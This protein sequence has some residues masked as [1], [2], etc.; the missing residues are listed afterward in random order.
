VILYIVVHY[1]V[2]RRARSVINQTVCYLLALQ[3]HIGEFQYATKTDSKCVCQGGRQ[4]GSMTKKNVL[5]CCLPWSVH[6][7]ACCCRMRC[8]PAGRSRSGE[9]V[10]PAASCPKR[11]VVEG[12]PRT[13]EQAV[14]VWA[15]RGWKALDLPQHQLWNEVDH[16]L[17]SDP[18]LVCYG[19]SAQRGEGR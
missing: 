12:T 10:G 3:T 5:R 14:C 18:T 2:F 1:N 6:H 7:R 19:L 16:V 8:L 15:V 11:S 17:A 9:R 13:R 4:R